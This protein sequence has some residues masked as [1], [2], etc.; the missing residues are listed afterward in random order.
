M[1]A[2]YEIYAMISNTLLSTGRKFFIALIIA[3]LVFLCYHA[4]ASMKHLSDSEKKKIVYSMYANYKRS[5]PD[6]MDIM[7]NKAME[8]MNEK[9][10]VLL[11]ARTS[12]ERQV[13][14][15]PGAISYEQLVKNPEEYRDKI[16]INYCTIS[17]RSAK[18]TRQLI[19]QGWTAYNLSG[20]L[21]A[22]LLEGGK[23]YDAS[24]ETRR[25][26][27]YGKRW[28]YP[29]DGYEAVW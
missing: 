19:K 29:P 9:Q 25:I 18:L 22:W 10:A 21:L 7:P 23:V 26:H 12:S 3:P 11:D 14:M 16:I 4:S 1:E 6:V 24:G 8:L 15:L 2:D 27:V 17:Y 13:S 20:G 5:F 28:N